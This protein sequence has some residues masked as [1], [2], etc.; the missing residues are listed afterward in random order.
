MKIKQVSVF[1]EN[2]SGRLAA[3]TKA[4]AQNKLNI[5]ALSIADTSDFGILRLIVNKPED[6]YRVLKEEGFTVSIAEVIGVA[7]PDTPGGLADILEVLEDRGVDIEYIYAFVG[8]ARPD[9]L[10]ICRVENIDDA[11]EVLQ[12]KGI[13][14]LSGEKVYSL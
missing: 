9:A 12:E 1:L 4:L 2:K 7:M 10:V 13:N 8:S 3:V 6:A 14:I 5:R 11:I